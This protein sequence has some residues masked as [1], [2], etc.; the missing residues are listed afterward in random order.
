MP[1]N[2]IQ[3]KLLEKL[4]LEVMQTEEMKVSAAEMIDEGMH[5]LVS[6]INKLEFA[7]V[8]CGDLRSQYEDIEADYRELAALRQ[9]Q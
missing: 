7:E 4:L 6:G 3:L 2:K 5:S 1:L 8:E 9:L